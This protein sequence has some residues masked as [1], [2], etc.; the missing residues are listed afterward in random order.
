MSRREPTNE[1]EVHANPR[2]MLG[3]GPFA[4]TWDVPVAAGAPMQVTP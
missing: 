4:R 2:N 3:A 1:V